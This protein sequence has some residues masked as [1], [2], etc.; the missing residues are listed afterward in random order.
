MTLRLSHARTRVERLATAMQLTGLAN[1][2][3][4]HALIHYSWRA[5]PTEPVPEWPPRNAPTHCQHGH[6]IEHV[7][8]VF[9]WGSRS[10]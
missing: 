4:A 9:S 7:H 8:Y 2:L 3:E 6:P 10:G 1:C 5:K